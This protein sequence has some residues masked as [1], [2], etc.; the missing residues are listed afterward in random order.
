MEGC[1]FCKIVRGE[2][3]S[4]KV[5]ED[6]DFV[7]FLDIHPESPGHV[8][9]IPKAHYRWIWDVP[10]IGKYFEVAQ[11]IAKAQQKVFSTEW[12]IQ[13]SIG[14]EVAHAHVWIFPGK[15]EGDKMDFATNAAKLRAALA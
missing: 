11:K 9:L 14:D 6:D 7:A 10:N 8:Q 5:Y 4:Y 2:L 12:I 1:V 15:A 3:P 13:K